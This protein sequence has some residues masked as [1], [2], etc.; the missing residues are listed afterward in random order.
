V[1]LGTFTLVQNEQHHF[2]LQFS[3]K[4]DSGSGASRPGIRPD[5]AMFMNVGWNGR[6]EWA[7]VNGML[8]KQDARTEKRDNGLGVLTYT[9]KEFET[10]PN[11]RL[12]GR[13][14]MRDLDVFVIEHRPESGAVAKLYFDVGTYE[15]VAADSQRRG[16]TG[17]FE[18]LDW[19]VVDGEYMPSRVTGKI[20]GK[21]FGLVISDL[22]Y[23]PAID[24][25]KFSP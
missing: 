17:R 24:E 23:D 14:K 12:I 15:L 7:K 4:P 5:A 16:Q 8:L 21:D 18:F 11:V 6:V 22:E 2:A 9:E 20:D 25:S 3:G 19:K 13:E 1:F 10:N